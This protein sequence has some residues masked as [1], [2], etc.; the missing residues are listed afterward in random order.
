MHSASFNQLISN[1]DHLEELLVK[2][3]EQRNELIYNIIGLDKISTYIKDLPGL[4]NA[5]KILDLDDDN[6]QAFLQKLELNKLV[7]SVTELNW[8]LSLVGPSLQLPVTISYLG[9][10][11]IAKLIT[12]VESFAT[13]Y[14]M[15]DEP[16]KEELL[17]NYDVKRLINIPSR[18]KELLRYFPQNKSHIINTVVGFEHVVLLAS[19]SVSNYH[20]I[21]TVLDEL[22]NRELL[23]NLN[24]DVLI[25]NVSALCNFMYE[26][27]QDQYGFILSNVVGLHRIKKLVSNVENFTSI[28]CILRDPEQKL[29]FDHVEFP[30]EINSIDDIYEILTVTGRPYR[31]KLLQQLVGYNKLPDELKQQGHYLVKLGAKHYTYLQN[32]L[33]FEKEPG[34]ESL[35]QTI[36][37]IPENIRYEFMAEVIGF[38]KLFQYVNNCDQLR[39]TLESVKKDEEHDE[40]INN[41]SE[42][43]WAGLIKSSLNFKDYANLL[44][45]RHLQTMMSK[46]SDKKLLAL[47]PRSAT[48]DIVCDQLSI[49]GLNS[50]K[51]D[52]IFSA[53]SDETCR[54]LVGSISILNKYLRLLS[55]T[56]RIDFITKI[57]PEALMELCE[58]SDDIYEL[59]NFRDIQY[60]TH[61]I[62]LLGIDFIAEFYYDASFDEFIRL[63]DAVHDNDLKT[64]VIKKFS[65]LH[66]L[67]DYEITAKNLNREK[68]GLTAIQF[69]ELLKAFGSRKLSEVFTDTRSV[70]GL[71]SKLKKDD[72]KYKSGA[73]LNIA[74][75]HEFKLMMYGTSFIAVGIIGCAFALTAAAAVVI[76]PTLGVTVLGYMGYNIGA[77]AVTL[78]TAIVSSAAIATSVGSIVGGV[79]ELHKRAQIGR[80]TDSVCGRSEVK[81]SLGIGTKPLSA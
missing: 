72:Y 10:K 78:G 61:I 16:G 76:A 73:L 30:Y 80:L 81:H 58:T 53:L 46:F 13:T 75:S 12:T 49:L 45:P 64:Q 70:I 14:D 60:K 28:W 48:L 52:V 65:R 74:E 31:F 44:K 62:N 40:I 57:G 67:D 56:S 15:L 8:L 33:N 9:V 55:K 77:T 23:L 41:V 51:Y 39:L 54:S 43:K 5:L 50:S 36:D 32:Y 38:E 29:I 25:P 68:L 22:N 79:Y 47:I 26:V 19:Q 1:L 6:K 59:V 37:S 17:A 34:F 2:F 27:D 7:N 20:Q 69:D 24:F 35:K 71:L 63:L 18:F 66:C 4:E 3:P 11:N 42:A 21:K